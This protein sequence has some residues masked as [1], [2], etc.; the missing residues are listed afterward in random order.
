MMRV[1]GVSRLIWASRTN[2]YAASA[3]INSMPQESLVHCQ[4][5]GYSRF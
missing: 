2:G 4:I 5:L 1:I 3:K